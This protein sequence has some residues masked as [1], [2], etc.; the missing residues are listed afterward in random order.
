MQDKRTAKR[1]LDKPGSDSCSKRMCL[2]ERG[3]PPQNDD[4]GCIITGASG[5]NI[6]YV[7]NPGNV[8]IQR[9]W[10][11]LLNLQYVGAMRPR[12]GSPTTPLTPPTRT[13]RIPGDGN[14]LF[15]ALSYIITGTIDQQAAIRAVILNHMSTIEGRLRRG[16]FPPCYA[17]AQS[18]IEGTRMNR[19]RTWGSDCEMITMADLLNTTILYPHDTA[20]NVWAPYT[21][22]GGI[23]PTVPALYLQWQ[24][25]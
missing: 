5:P 23:D 10:C 22:A 11:G 21:P 20:N 6:Y 1:S 8:T 9:Y 15:S 17:D 4:G 25:F 13:V 24:P 16:F 14:C 12:L 3:T 18:Y 2:D 19:D 7:Y